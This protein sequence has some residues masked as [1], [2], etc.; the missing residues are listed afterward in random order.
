[1]CQKVSFQ[2]VP[3]F[4]GGNTAFPLQE[5]FGEIPNLNPYIINAFTLAVALRLTHCWGTAVNDLRRLLALRWSRVFFILLR[6]KR[7]ATWREKK[8]GQQ[9][10]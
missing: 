3:D 7:G 1:M 10:P 4:P 9:W 2:K 8:N 6:G 5:Q